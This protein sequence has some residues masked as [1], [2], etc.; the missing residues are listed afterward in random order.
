MDQIPKQRSQ[1]LFKAY[2]QFEKKF[3]DR[4]GIESVIISKRKLQYEEEVKANPMNY[5]AWVDYIRLI[6]AEGSLEMIREVYERAISNV[7]PSPEK[8]HW[9]RYIYLWIYYALYEELNAK[10]M[11]HTRQVYRA[12]LEIIPHSQF[13]FAKIWLMYAHFEV[14]QKDITA[15]R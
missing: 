8:R 12:C 3:G 2:S 10:D 14:R 15:A 9:R 13:T 4:A 5:D 1:E 11:E 6:E 7:P